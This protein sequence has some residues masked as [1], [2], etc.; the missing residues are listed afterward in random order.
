MATYDYIILNNSN[1]SLTKR[2][3]AVAMKMSKT[4]TDNIDRAVGGSTDKQAGTI[5]ERWQYGLRVPV[6]TAQSAGSD[7]GLWSDLETFY[8]YNNPN[9]TPSD[10]ITLTDHY[11]QTHTVI[12]VGDIAPEP[13]CTILEG[14]AAYYIVQVAFEEVL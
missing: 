9:G 13:L 14:D 7:Y 2:F 12:F 3:K 5:I 10:K 8:G 1:S 6:Y 4:R 11:G